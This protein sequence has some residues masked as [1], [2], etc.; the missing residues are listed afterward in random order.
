VSAIKL[1]SSC[2]CWQMTAVLLAI[3]INLM[4]GSRS[5]CAENVTLQWEPSP[6][7]KAVGY[8]VHITKATKEYHFVIDVGNVTYHVVQDLSED[9]DYIFYVTA[10]DSIGIESEPSNLVFR[11]TAHTGIPARD[12]AI[13]KQFRNR[14]LAT[15]TIGRFILETYETISTPLTDLY[16]N[17]EIFRAITKWILAVLAIVL[18]HPLRSIVILVTVATILCIGIF[19]HRHRNRKISDNI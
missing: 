6:S 14:Y 17:S 16:H 13:L 11:R 19:F 18:Q 3:I 10:H 7:A 12:I 5:C 4:P 15:N 9:E 1:F 8:K 2:G